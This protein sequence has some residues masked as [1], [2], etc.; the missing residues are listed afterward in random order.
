MSS[1]TVRAGV[2]GALALSPD[3][4]EAGSQIRQVFEHIFAQGTANGEVD[5]IYVDS[6]SIA[7][8]ATTDFD[9]AGSLTDIYGLPFTPVEIAAIIVYADATNTNNVEVG[10]DSNSVPF[11]KDKTDVAVVRPG[12]IYLQ[13]FGGAGVTVT[14]STGDI[15]QL[16]NSS[17]GS[18]VTGKVIILGR[19][20]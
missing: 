3:L 7:A 13:T 4:G 6:F 20:A 18:A 12:S 16:A 11:L 2:S 9:L 5:K 1:I 8:S 14:A 19:S 17:S 15:F 10:G